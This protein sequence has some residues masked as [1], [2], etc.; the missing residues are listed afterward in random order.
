MLQSTAMRI[1]SAS[2]PAGWQVAQPLLVVNE[3]YRFTT[4]EQLRQVNITAA[5]IVLEPCGRNTAPAA[6]HIHPDEFR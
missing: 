2:M 6:V 1:D 5:A 3:E 4:A